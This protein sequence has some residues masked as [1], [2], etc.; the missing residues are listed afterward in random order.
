MSGRARVSGEERHAETGMFDRQLAYWTKQLAGA[1]TVL[2]L[3]SD[4]PRPSVRSLRKGTH[5]FALPWA[6]GSSLRELTKQAQAT[7][8]MALITVFA[9]L[10]YRYTG[11]NDVLIGSPVTG[12]TL[13]DFEEITGF[14]VN[15]LVL[16]TKLT[17]S[18]TFA[19]L[20]S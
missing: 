19:D 11:Q 8:F 20:L 17:G 14:F 5:R 13:A 7:P 10:L 1:P 3:P 2:E 6:L 18:L 16:R 15:L 4:R 12:G 9:I